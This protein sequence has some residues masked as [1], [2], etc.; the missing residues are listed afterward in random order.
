MEFICRSKIEN[1][2]TEMPSALHIPLPASLEKNSAILLSSL[3]S[4]IRRF[5]SISK[6]L[7]RKK[8]QAQISITNYVK[9]RRRHF[10]N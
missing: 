8:L 1:R 2:I 7:P 6:H 5:S 9:E 10:L 4:L 3:I